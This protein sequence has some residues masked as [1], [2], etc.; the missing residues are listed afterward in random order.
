MA[1]SVG[2]VPLLVMATLKVLLSDPRVL[3]AVTVTT[4]LLIQARSRV[5]VSVLPEK[6]K[7]ACAWLAGGF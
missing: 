1:A 2:A 5:M 6:A 3:L 7:V 4:M